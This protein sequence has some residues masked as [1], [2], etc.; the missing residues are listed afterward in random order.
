MSSDDNRRWKRGITTKTRTDTDWKT[1]QRSSRTDKNAEDE[2]KDENDD[3]S[4]GFQDE[5]TKEEASENSHLLMF[6][7]TDTKTIEFTWL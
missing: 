5:N 7:I 2:S 6:V 1:L 3:G 4:N